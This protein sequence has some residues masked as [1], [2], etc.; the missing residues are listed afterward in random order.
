MRTDLVGI[1]G[2]LFGYVIMLGVQAL[3]SFGL[4]IAA[5]IIKARPSLAG[6]NSFLPLPSLVFYEV[7]NL[8]L[9]LYTVALYV[10]MVKRRKSAIV[11]NVICNALAVV[12]LACWHLLGMKSGLGM[13]LDSLPSVVGVCYILASRRVRNTFVLT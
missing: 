11:N 10:L 4:T 1:R 12:F 5:L 7:S 13:I 2:W 8:F 9:V 3:H 6:L